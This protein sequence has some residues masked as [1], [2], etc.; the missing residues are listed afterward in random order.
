MLCT[1]VTTIWPRPDQSFLL[2]VTWQVGQHTWH[3]FPFPSPLVHFFPSPSLVNHHWCCPWSR[4]WLLSV[5]CWVCQCQTLRTCII[6]LLQ[7]HGLVE[8]ML[9]GIMGGNGVEHRWMLSMCHRWSG[10][11][12]E[13]CGLRVCTKFLL[14]EF[15][16]ILSRKE[17]TCLV[18]R[19]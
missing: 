18:C 7:L 13:S 11:D 4:L 19:A 8:Q 6:W 2:R 3:T 15:A 9:V 12:V 5:S 1:G 10:G 16:D 17:V 14:T